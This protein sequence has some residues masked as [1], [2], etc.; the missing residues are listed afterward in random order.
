MVSRQRGLTLLELLFVVAVIS[1]LMAVVGVSVTGLRTESVLGQVKSDGD[2]TQTQVV[3]FNNVSIN[4]GQFPERRPDQVVGTSGASTFHISADVVDVG[5][6]GTGDGK[7]VVLVRLDG[8]GEAL[9]DK[10]TPF[11][12]VPGAA[13]FVRRMI[14]FG[15]TTDLWDQGGDVKSTT[16]V[17]DFLP[18]EPSSL[19]L[20]GDE[21]KDLGVANNV[22]EEFLWL[23]LANAPE[24]DAESR[25]VQ[26]FRLVAADCSGAVSGNADIAGRTQPDPGRMTASAVSSL[27]ADASGC[28]SSSDTVAAL[29]YEVVFGDIGQ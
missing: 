22:Y 12:A 19:V 11:G 9:A 2:A 24:T 26:V 17:P 28:T 4:T 5:T 29:I 3:N 20:K 6:A 25:T 1:V 27:R 18:K 14:D 15:A 21:T 13:V 8:K 10:V 23:V 7:N 16:F